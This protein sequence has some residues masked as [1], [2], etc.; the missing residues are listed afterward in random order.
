MRVVAV[1]VTALLLASP[2]MAKPDPAVGKL[3]RQIVAL[4]AQVK[5][6]QKD[7]ALNKSLAI[8]YYALGQDSFRVAFSALSSLTEA[9]SGK[10]VSAWDAIQK[11]D[12]QGACSAVGIPRP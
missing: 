3:Q 11:F 7:V 4:Q 10:R 8:C 2:A 9:V 12:D 1:A 5:Q 6:L